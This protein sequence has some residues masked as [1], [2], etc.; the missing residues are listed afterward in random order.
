MAKDVDLSSSEWI[1][2]IFEGKNKDFGAYSLRKASAKRH[3]RA[4]LVIIIVLL[5]V[6][7]LGLVANTVLQQVEAAPEDQ[8]EQALIDYAQEDQKDDEPEDEPEQQRV[9]EQQPEALPEEILNTVKA[10][11]LAIVRDEEV[12]E[13]IKSQDELKDTDTAVGTTDFDKGTDDLNVVREHKDEVIVEE[14]R[15][16]PVEDNRVFDVVEQKPQFPG[17]DAALLKFIQEH[18]H[19]PPMA[20]ENNIQ[21]RVVVQFVVTKTGAVGD[22]RVV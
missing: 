2:L 9:E 6:A 7:I 15:P 14:K 10:T 16:E 12:S 17:G 19:Y 4:M 11:E 3:N 21:G 8:I 18:L 22:V 1:D 13:E 20:Q 5:I